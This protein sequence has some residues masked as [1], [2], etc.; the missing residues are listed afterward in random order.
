MS[1]VK[2]DAKLDERPRGRPLESSPSQVAGRWSQ[3]APNRPTT[4]REPLLGSRPRLVEFYDGED[5]T[6]HRP[7]QRPKLLLG[8]FLLAASAAAA[9]GAVYAVL[10][11]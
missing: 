8:L 1:D 3:H 10:S 4:L 9:C 7:Q 11:L 6:L 5:Q 2:V